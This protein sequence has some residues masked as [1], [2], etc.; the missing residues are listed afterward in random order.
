MP[1]ACFQPAEPP[2]SDSEAQWNQSSRGQFQYSGTIPPGPR[3]YAAYG[4]SQDIVRVPMRTSEQVR[5]NPL[6]NHGPGRQVSK[7]FNRSGWFNLRT[8]AKQRLHLQYQRERTRDQQEIVEIAVHE[9]RGC[10]L[11][12]HEAVCGIKHAAKQK[13]PVPEKMEWRDYSSAVIAKPNR[14]A[15]A[16]LV[17]KIICAS[18]NERQ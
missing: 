16:S 6:A 12:K 2:S 13:K 18:S 3:S 14:T 4:V 7:N 8:N 9:R 10:E 15:I 1:G 17:N 11:L 5:T